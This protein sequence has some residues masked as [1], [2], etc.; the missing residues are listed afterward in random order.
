M[1][2]VLSLYPF[3][4]KEN[5]EIIAIEHNGETIYIKVDAFKPSQIKVSFE[6][7]KTFKVM[8]KKLSELG[9]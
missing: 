8:R 5:P 4:A 7:P 1:A 6:G 9:K 3:R 2:L